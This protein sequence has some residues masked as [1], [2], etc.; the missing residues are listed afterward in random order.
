MK[1]FVCADL[2]GNRSIMKK[3]PQVA[4]LVDAIFI[5]GDIGGKGM[6]GKTFEEFSSYQKQVRLI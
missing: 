2:H 5:C 6:G 4:N 1:I 3:I